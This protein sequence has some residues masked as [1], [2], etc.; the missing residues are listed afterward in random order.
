MNFGGTILELVYMFLNTIKK[1]GSLGAHFLLPISQSAIIPR[2]NF[3]EAKFEPIPVPSKIECTY[4]KWK[5]PW[6]PA[7]HDVPRNFWGP[8]KI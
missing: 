7:S 6:P 8:K 2:F 1:T 3:M 4:A 5:E